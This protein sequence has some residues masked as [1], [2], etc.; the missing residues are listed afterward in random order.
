M[1]RVLAIDLKNRKILTELQIS[2]YIY[3]AKM[4]EINKAEYL[5]RINI[6]WN[7][8]RKIKKRREENMITLGKTNDLR[9]LKATRDFCSFCP[10]LQ[11]NCRAF[12]GSSRLVDTGSF[13]Q[14][15]GRCWP[16]LVGVVHWTLTLTSENREPI[17][18][19]TLPKEL[20]QRGRKGGRKEGKRRG[21]EMKTWKDACTTLK[22]FRSMLCGGG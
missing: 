19:Q 8:Q 4:N 22:M 7:W 1:D 10:A 3:F 17:D 6:C 9:T 12:R 15:R 2:S 16:W 18:G 21:G 14:S 13:S 5:A 20:G 11:R